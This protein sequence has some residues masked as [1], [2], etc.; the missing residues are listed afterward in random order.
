MLDNRDM[1]DLTKILI[2]GGVGLVTGLISGIFLE[3]LKTWYL[4]KFTARRARLAM[5]RELGAL[6]R[7]IDAYNV[8]G[9]FQGFDVTVTKET[10]FE[11]FDYFHGAY[12]EAVYQIEEWQSLREMFEAAN[13]AQQK[14]SKGEDPKSVYKSLQHEFD[15][16][17]KCRLSSS[18]DLFKVQTK[19]LRGRAG[20][21][22]IIKLSPSPP[23]PHKESQ[24][25]QSDS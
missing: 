14:L 5:Y 19:K 20:P 15:E 18:P 3:P 23:E 2:S 4:R 11:T 7:K 1:S 13:K 22:L 9:D 24:E 16:Y 12:R 17:L 10:D 8:F 21:D 25:P 6:Y